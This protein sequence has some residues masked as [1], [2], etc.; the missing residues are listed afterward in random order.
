MLNAL[1][2]DI[3][4]GKAWNLVQARKCRQQKFRVRMEHQKSSQNRPLIGRF[5]SSF[6][7]FEDES[8]EELRE[9]PDYHFMID[10]ELVVLIL[11]II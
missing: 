11:I 5:Y 6:E 8:E 1:T 2:S 7:D 3:V 4:L 10:L 9:I